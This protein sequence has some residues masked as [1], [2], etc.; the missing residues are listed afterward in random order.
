MTS[1]RCCSLA[2][3][4]WDAVW[5]LGRSCRHGASKNSQPIKKELRHVKL[6]PQRKD[7]A[8]SR[9]STSFSSTSSAVPTAITAAAK[10][11]PAS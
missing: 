5:D 2:C 3:S 9:R 10:Y 6:S 11:R 1:R 4:T 8:A 7:G